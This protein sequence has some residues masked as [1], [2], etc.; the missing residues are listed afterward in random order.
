VGSSVNSWNAAYLE[1]QYRQFQADPASVPPDLRSFFQ[2]FDLAMAGG[3]PGAPVPAGP[4]TADALRLRYAI[5]RLIEAYRSRGH[6]AASLDPFDRP[7]PRPAELAP[8]YHGLTEADLGRPVPAG[9]AAAGAGGSVQQLID[10]LERTYCG[11]IGAEFMHVSDEAERRWLIERFERDGGRI[12]LTRADRAHIL[13]QL[14]RSEQFEVF[15]QK[16]YADQKRF[17]LEGGESLI[18]FLDRVVE[19]CGEMGVEEIVMGMPH[20]GRLNVLNNTLGKTYEQIFTEFEDNWEDDAADSGGDVKYH[21]G[22]SGQRTL[23]GGRVVHLAMASNPSHLESVNGVV[24]GRCRAKQRLRADRERRRVI[25]LLIHGDAAVIAQGVVAEV[26]NFS[27]LEG[28]TTGG[29]IHVV[30]NNLI[31]F[32]TGPEDA[33]SSRYCTD[34]ALMVEAPVFHVNGDDPEAVVACAQFAAE[35]RQRFRKDVFVDLW[36]FRRYGHNEQDEPSFTQ[37][38]LAALIKAEPGPLTTYARRLRAE[39]VIGDKDIDAI[40]ARLDSALEAAQAAARQS[41]RDPNI[42]PG[43]KRWEGCGRVYSF[44]PVQTGVPR[45]MLAEV[46]AALGRVPDGFNLNPKLRRLLES[47]ASILRT[48]SVSYADAESLAFGTLLL[49]GHGVRLTG[50]DSRRG[51][52]SHRHAVLRDFK[53]GEPYTP[54]NHMR[55]VAE[56]PDDAG[57][58]GPDG[59]PT[60]GRF[61]VYDSPLSEF[62][63]MAFDYGYSLADPRMFV[64][65]EAQFGDFCNGAQVII[66]QYLASAEAKWERWSGLTLLLPHGYEGAGPEH[67]SARLERFLQLC[68][69]ENMEVV[70]PTS[71]AQ[72]FHLFRRHLK[73]PFRKPLVVMTPKSMLRDQAYASPVEDLVSGSFRE[74]IDDPALADG[75]AARSVR[76]VLLCSGKIACELSARRDALRRLDTAIIRVEQLYPLHVDL[77]RSIL[78][79]YPK[80]AAVTWVQEEP[81]NAGAYL[82]MADVVRARLGLDIR[83]IGRPASA[84]PAVASKHRHKEQQEAILAEA[85]GPAPAA[86]PPHAGA[87]GNGDATATTR[88]AAAKPR[89]GVN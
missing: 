86:A 71:G 3:G 7:R 72:L 50:Q 8:A 62:A 12:P 31:G 34:I 79:R 67:S 61:C 40:R 84:T 23:R 63:V 24:E 59:R 20:R 56:R 74:I 1:S 60:Q 76:Q 38:I 10:E 69:N 21:K 43:S 33:R 13:D 17:S 51:T 83:Y 15:L 66:D 37:P 46:C 11:S 25:P 6:L 4:D 65:W 26:L 87:A 41:P 80:P 88:P 82:Y 5:E 47:R 57:L 19:A 39:G 70:N 29:T 55:P 27:R 75:D 77:L 81:R 58:P 32:T 16:R 2:G 22:Y 45:E 9:V 35:Y 28:Y 78:A 48:G 73:R 42:D 36:C 44:D 85:I 52:F 64:L 68:A 18:A 14:V 89:A 54:L 30:L 49:E 53:T